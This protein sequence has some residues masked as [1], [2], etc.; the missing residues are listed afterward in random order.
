MKYIFT[1]LF[2]LTF[3]S[4]SFGL[5]K[6][7]ESYISNR[8]NIKIGYSNYSEG[9]KINNEIQ[10]TPHLRLECNY[11]LFQFLETGAYLGISSF[12]ITGGTREEY[13]KDE[14]LTPF[15]GININFHLLPFFIKA[16]DFRIDFYLAGRF[17]GRY[18][19][20]PDNYYYNGHYNEYGIGPGISF[21]LLKHVGIFTEFYLGKFHFKEFVSE[22]IKDNDMI[23]FGLS[24]KFL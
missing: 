14:Y 18:I 12:E 24:F 1:T 17:G 22:N 15:Y 21:Y 10:T 20:T 6:A 9:Y 11:G 8:L 19:T 5:I 16:N 23:R 13:S 3:Y 2:I 7:Q 4:T